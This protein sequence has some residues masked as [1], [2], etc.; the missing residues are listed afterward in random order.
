M[1]NHARKI[2][3]WSLLLENDKTRDQKLCTA[4]EV[5]H[6]VASSLPSSRSRSLAGIR[7]SWERNADTRKESF[8]SHTRCGNATRCSSFFFLIFTSCIKISENANAEAEESKRFGL[9]YRWRN[10]P[11]IQRYF[12]IVIAA[13]ALLL[14]TACTIHHRPRHLRTRTSRHYRHRYIITAV[15]INTITVYSIS[16]LLLR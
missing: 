11:F 12:V 9:D 15:T 2:T 6:L 3:R 7:D 8:S 13:L 16:F 14:A 5:C 4:M 1:I 10:S